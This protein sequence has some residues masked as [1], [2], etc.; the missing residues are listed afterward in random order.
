MQHEMDVVITGIHIYIIIRYI[1]EME[2]APPDMLLYHSVKE[3]DLKAY[4]QL[5]MKYTQ[6][7]F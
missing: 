5:E 1:E 2:N 6:M 4:K 7:V 3:F